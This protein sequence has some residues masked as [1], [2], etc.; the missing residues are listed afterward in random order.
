VLNNQNVGGEMF[1]SQ[2]VDRLVVT[3]RKLRITHWRHIDELLTFQ[4]RQVILQ[5]K[6]TRLHATFRAPRVEPRCLL[7]FSEFVSSS[8]Y[9]QQP[10]VAVANDVRVTEYDRSGEEIIRPS[11]L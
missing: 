11:F 5:K 6:V 3:L 9:V 10:D 2:Y 7:I 4:S 8:T 1:R